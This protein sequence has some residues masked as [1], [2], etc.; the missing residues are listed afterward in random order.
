MVV[1]TSARVLYHARQGLRSALAVEDGGARTR[2][3]PLNIVA[4]LPETHSPA[5]QEQTSATAA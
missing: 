5:D 1:D 2:F 3:A 4:D